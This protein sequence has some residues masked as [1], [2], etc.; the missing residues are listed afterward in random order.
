ML[1]LRTI[2][3]CFH[4]TSIHTV[5]LQLWLSSA[6]IWLQKFTIKHVEVAKLWF[7][8]PKSLFIILSILIDPLA[9]YYISWMHKIECKLV[10]GSLDHFIDSDLWVSFSKIKLYFF[11]SFRSFLAKHNSNVRV[12]SLTHILLMQTLITL[13]T[14]QNYNAIRNRKD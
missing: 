1:D 11:K 4:E 12:T 14:I 2:D 10:M 13:Q 5:L 3:H 9:V 6:N 7:P 8:P